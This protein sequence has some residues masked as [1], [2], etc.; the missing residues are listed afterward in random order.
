RPPAT[1][2][3]RGPRDARL[4]RHPVPPLCHACGE[5]DVLD[6]RGP[7]LGIFPRPHFPQITT[8]LEPGDVL[9][10][11]TSGRKTGV[12]PN[13]ILYASLQARPIT[14]HERKMLRLDDPIADSEPRW[15]AGLQQV[16]CAEQ[17]VLALLSSGRRGVSRGGAR[18]GSYGE[19][20]AG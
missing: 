8:D 10:L 13:R 1:P 11:H 6:A 17:P 9:L 7:F 3:G 18:A 5:I 15:L 20:G 12:P 2:P 14:Q 19:F 4:R 16:R